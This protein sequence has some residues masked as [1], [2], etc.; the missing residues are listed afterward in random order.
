V[1]TGAPLEQAMA[2]LVAHGF[3][4]VQ[5]VPAAHALQVPVLPHTPLPP[6]AAVQEEPAVT[7]V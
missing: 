5:D 6:P 7:N 4:D 2:A 3:V 1:H